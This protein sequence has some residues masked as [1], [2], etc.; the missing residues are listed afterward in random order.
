ML[1]VCDFKL[2]W[3]FLRRYNETMGE[4]KSGHLP[5]HRAF[6]APFR[7]IEEGGIDPIL[8]GLFGSAAKRQT[9]DQIMNTELIEKLFKLAH[10]VALGNISL[11][12]LRMFE[13]EVINHCTCFAKIPYRNTAALSEVIFNYLRFISIS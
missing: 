13:D 4:H 8:R 7:V 3:R 6:F 11:P 2:W 10:A 9:S 5:L 1:S 12:P